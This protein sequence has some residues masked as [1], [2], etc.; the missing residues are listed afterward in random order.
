M[1]WPWRKQEQEAAQAADAARQELERVKAQWPE[2]RRIGGAARGHKE[3]NHLSQL[4]DHI[5][6]G[7]G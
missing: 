1:K 3:A 6:S 7:R 2:A 4:F 5:I